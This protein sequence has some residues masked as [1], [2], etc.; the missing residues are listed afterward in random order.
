MYGFTLAEVLVAS[1]LLVVAVVTILQGLAIY[2]RTAVNVK[3]RTR[4]LTLARAKL[5]EVKAKSVYH[6]DTNFAELD[7]NYSPYLCRVSDPNYG[8]PNLRFIQVDAGYDN[9]DGSDLDADEVH[10]ILKTLITDRWK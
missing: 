6:Y 7:A 4:S 8:D 3:Y 5:D 9:D 1:T 2:H 10:V